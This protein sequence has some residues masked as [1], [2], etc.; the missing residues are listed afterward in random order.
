MPGCDWGMM[1]AKTRFFFGGPLLP[2]FFCHPMH[3]K[4]SGGGV[5]SSEMKVTVPGAASCCIGQW[6]VASLVAV[7]WDG[8]VRKG[9]IEYL[10]R[11]QR[12][13]PD[14]A[15]R[16]SGLCFLSSAALA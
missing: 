3:R 15:T 13:E 14:V 2:V 8:R 16:W 12:R 6:S 7:V 5:S 10:G 1:S 11:S 4:P 9:R